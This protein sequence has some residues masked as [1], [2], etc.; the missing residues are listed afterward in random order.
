MDLLKFSEKLMSMDEKSWQRHA[1]PYSVYSRF[2]TL[3]LISFAFWSRSIWDIYA[4]I[5]IFISFVWVW[6]NPRIFSAPLNTH[7]W[8]SMGTF[9]ERIYLNRKVEAIPEHHLSVCNVLMAL[10]LIGLP[11]W[12]YGVYTLDVWAIAFGTSWLMITK[13]WFVDRMVWLYL[14]LKDSNPRYQSWLKK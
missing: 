13:A 3:P 8:A 14:D 1:S 10:Q 7:N 4:L 12:L 11:L 9:G 2:T 6:L 5:P